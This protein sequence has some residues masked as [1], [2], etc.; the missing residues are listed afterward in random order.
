MSLIV[1]LLFGSMVSA[2]DPRSVLSI[3]KEVAVDDRLSVLVEGESLL[4]DGTAV[5]FYSR[6]LSPVQSVV[7]LA[8]CG[9][10]RF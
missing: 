9:V 5:A 1:A 2:T 7:K 10:L 8:L 6:F 4:N 3:F